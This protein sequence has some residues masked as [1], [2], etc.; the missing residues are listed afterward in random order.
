MLDKFKS[1]EITKI[2]K[3]RVYGIPQ[4]KHE[5]LNAYLFKDSKKSLVYISN[6]PKTG[7]RKITTEYR[8]IE[9]NILENTSIL[10][11]I[12]HT[13]RTHQIR[14]HLSYIGYPIIRRSENMVTIK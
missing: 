6:K 13:G 14:A 3:C 12:L 7:Y 5:I 10:E 4:K 8:V 9:E 11:I 1:N 2:Y